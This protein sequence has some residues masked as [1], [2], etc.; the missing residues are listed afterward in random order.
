MA[1]P[2]V[3]IVI[4]TL[5]AAESLAEC[6]DSVRQLDF[7]QERLETIVV[8]NASSDGTRKLLEKRYPWVRALRQEANLGFAEAVNVGARAARA[9]LLAFA[10]DDMRLDPGWLRALVTA[11]GPDCACVAGLILDETGER[12][13][14]AGGYM[15]FY[16]MAGQRGFGEPLL[17]IAVEDGAEVLF[18]CGGSMLVDRSVFLELSGFDPSFF[19]YFEDVDLGWR[20]WLAGH[21]VRLAAEARSFHRGSMTSGALPMHQRLLLYERNALLLLYKNLGEEHV[22]RLLA[23]AL[24]LAAERAKLDTGYDV[25]ALE[26]GAPWPKHDRPVRLDGLARLEAISQFLGLL[27]EAAERRAQVQASRKRP[28]AELFALFGQPF[29]PYS[30]RESYIAATER[31]TRTFGILGLFPD[32]EWP[33]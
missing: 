19:A 24:L 25:A 4:P 10:N 26:P 14:F 28:D 23:A 3:A 30:S 1:E 8:D 27:D 7:P 22:Y 17:D 32:Q 31:V 21:T 18:A 16:G 29:W 5:S 9:D 20:L 13:D 2:S 12:V 15:S 33:E 6:L 11:H